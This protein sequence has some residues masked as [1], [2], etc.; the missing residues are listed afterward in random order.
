MHKRDNDG[1]ENI[2]AISEIYKVC[3]LL[4]RTEIKGI[5]MMLLLLLLL[6]LS[7]YTI[8]VVTLAIM[9]LLNYKSETQPMKLL[10]FGI[11]LI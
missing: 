6:L 9:T 10:V 1:N 7:Y 5:M 11:N 3:L 8:V 4:K 2:T